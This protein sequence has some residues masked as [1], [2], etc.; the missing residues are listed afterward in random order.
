MLADYGAEVIKVEPLDGDLSR[1]THPQGPAGGALFV[2]NNRNKRS[3]AIDLKSPDARQILD[4]LIADAD[5][6]LHNM[7]MVPARRLGLDFESVA[8]LNPRIVHCS[9]IGFGQDGPY[10]DRPAF[11]DIIQAASGIAGLACASGGEPRFVPTNLCDKVGALYAVQA[12]L[13][14][15]IA[16]GGGRAGAVRI[17]VPMFEAL[18]SFLM[19]E[20]LGAATFEEAGEPG[21]PRVLSE[22]RRPHRTRDGWIAILPYTGAQ[23]RRFFEEAGR[24]EICAEPW[25]ADSKARQARS[26]DL[27]RTAGEAL[28]ERTTA[29][30]MEALE[31]VD[32]PCSEV[33]T[34]D[35]LFEDPHLKAIGFFAPP[36]GYPGHI[37][38]VAPQPVRFDGAGEGI[39]RPPP[40]LGAHS[41]ELLRELGFSD[42]EIS[43]LAAAGAV[44]LGRGE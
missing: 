20:H 40:A 41:S 39:D 9:A 22:H 13:A 2:N 18:V 5:V 17:E 1:T 33:R 7:R 6:L 32:V 30:W 31:R 16:R 3:I 43:A 14:A 36:A 12:I 4:R 19:N 15:L 27:Y 11:D 28:A 44:R 8:E 25:F 21:Y 38:R 24:G 23:W 42:A 34:L 35:Q 37:K 26:A 29:E 10:R